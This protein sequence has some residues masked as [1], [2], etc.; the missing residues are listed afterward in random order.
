MNTTN[1]DMFFRKDINC[2]FGS[3]ISAGN[4]VNTNKIYIFTSSIV[5]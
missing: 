2:T 4:V 3:K 5:K 1:L